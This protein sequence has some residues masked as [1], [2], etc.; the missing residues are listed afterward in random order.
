M[1]VRVGPSERSLVESR[2]GIAEESGFEGCSIKVLFGEEFLISEIEESRHDVHRDHGGVTDAGFEFAFPG[3]DRGDADATFESPSFAGFER[4]VAGDAGRFF[5]MAMTP[6]VRGE[7]DDG[8]FGESEFVKL[9]HDASDVGVEV[10]HH[11]GIGGVVLTGA[12]GGLVTVEDF[13]GTAI[14]VEFLFLLLVF[15]NEFLGSLNRGVH[16]VV[17]E[18]EEEGFVL[19]VSDEIQGVIGEGVGEVVAFL[20]IFEVRDIPVVSAF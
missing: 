3:N 18:V 12:G 11:R 1:V 5:E 7:E 8:V 19:F 10:L 16:G 15:F 2:S 17:S 13:F 4:E 14:A 9:G 6:V 20:A